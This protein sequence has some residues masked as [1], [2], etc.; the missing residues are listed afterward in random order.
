[1]L[2]EFVME[3]IGVEDPFSPNEKD[4]DECFEDLV[5][6][7]NSLEDERVNKVLLINKLDS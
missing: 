2:P 4:D 5:S 6:L 7:M 3:N 1:M